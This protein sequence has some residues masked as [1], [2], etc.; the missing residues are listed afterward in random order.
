LIGTA[1]P[2]VVGMKVPRT[3]ATSHPKPSV[4]AA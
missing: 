3:V 4:K 1:R 2:T